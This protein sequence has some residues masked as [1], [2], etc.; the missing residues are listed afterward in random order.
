MGELR[1]VMAAHPHAVPV[2]TRRGSSTP[3]EVVVITDAVIGALDEGGV[4]GEAAVRTF[5][6]M[7]NYTVGFVV[8]GAGADDVDDATRAP[9]PFAGLDPGMLPHAAAAG[10]NLQ[11]FASGGG[12]ASDDQFRFGLDL[13]LDSIDAMA[14]PGAQR[15][16][17][18]ERDPSRP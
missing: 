14:D 1:R 7:F 9:D 10:Q 18:G 4:A 12:Y 2:F 13:I 3:A 5:Y 17:T 11:A 16:R 8:L 15:Q 6:A